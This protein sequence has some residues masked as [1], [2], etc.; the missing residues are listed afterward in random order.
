M[1]AWS[2]PN[3]R[4]V[5]VVDGDTLDALVT[6]DLGFGGVA[7]FPVRLRLNRINA[8]KLSTTRGRAACARVAALLLGQAVDIVTVKPYKYGGPDDQRGEYMAEVTLPDG[9]NLSDVLV[10]EKLAT[11]WDGQGARPADD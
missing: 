6:R 1:A 11:A 8:P 2:W 4:V 3:S 7:T 5:K 9:R 10:A